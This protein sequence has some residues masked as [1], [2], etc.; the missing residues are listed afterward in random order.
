MTTTR[1]HD[2][3]TATPVLY[4]AFE[5]GWGGWKLGF[6]TGPARAATDRAVTES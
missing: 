3:T 1:S 6:T 5:L 2:S 4:L